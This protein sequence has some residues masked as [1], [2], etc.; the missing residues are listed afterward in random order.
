MRNLEAFRVAFPKY[1]ERPTYFT[2]SVIK[3][4]TLEY[5]IELAEDV[6]RIAFKSLQD[7]MTLE[8]SKSLLRA[9]LKKAAEHAAKKDDKGF[10]SL[11]GVVNAM[12]EKA[13]TRNWQTLPHSISYA[14][15]PLKEGTNETTFV[16]RTH[17]GEVRHPFT[18]QAKKGQTLFHTFSSL[19]SMPA[20]Y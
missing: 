12:T 13:D 7:R 19:E 6:N 9:A 15:V 18:Y 11:V 8:F 10:G 4:D 2:S 20:R 5:R 14:R 1:V 3:V 16:L 17:E